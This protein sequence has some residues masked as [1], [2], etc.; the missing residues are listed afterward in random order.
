MSNA[1]RKPVK[2]LV[3]L[4]FDNCL[5]DT[6][7]TLAE[8]LNTA[9]QSY[10]ADFGT[11]PDELQQ[12]VQQS[13]G[14][15]RFCDF[16]GLSHNLKHTHNIPPQSD[17]PEQQ[18]GTDRKRREIR[19]DFFDHQT[20]NTAFYPGTLEALY[21]VKMKK[22][23]QVVLTDA[24][25]PALIR[26]LYLC[27]VNAGKD[28]LKILNLFDAFYAMPSIECDHR[29]L[30]GIDSDFI[31][32]MKQKMILS[33]A[34]HWK[35]CPDRLL[36][37]MADFNIQPDETILVGDTHKDLATAFPVG[38]DAVWF[39]RGTILNMGAEA[40]LKKYASPAYKYGFIDIEKEVK[41]AAQGRNYT[42]LYHSLAELVWHFTFAPAES[43]YRHSALSQA[44]QTP[45]AL[46]EL[47]HI[48][49]R[50]PELHKLFGAA[51]H[52]RP[53]HEM[54]AGSVPDGMA[55]PETARSPAEMLLALRQS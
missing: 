9:L 28:P 30:R 34:R 49:T 7:S 47:H 51:T 33:T 24:E 41:A 48:E 6:N 36:A 18:N 53:A 20:R 31:H 27:S 19:N 38:V 43:A 1:A 29:L 37:I 3:V 40:V 50:P 8:G 11:N 26:R 42:T 5:T 22:S 32:A 35:P 55:G 54:S 15:H 13:K 25:A 17:D 4:D 2:K 23:A 46:E 52:L 21:S 39:Q 44:C 10:I 14:Q 16:G 12:A 45:L